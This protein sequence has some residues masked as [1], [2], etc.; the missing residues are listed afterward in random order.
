DLRVFG[1][2][3]LLTTSTVLAFGL[4]PAL[5]ATGS[6]VPTSLAT[7]VV[8]S[9]GSRGWLSRGL[10]VGQ[11]LLCTVSLIVAGVFLRTVQNLRG[12]DA[13]YVEQQLLVADVQLPGGSDELRWA[14]LDQLH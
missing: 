7:R 4:L 5:R 12:Q 9:D 2:T 8:T 14:L 13:G 1:F 11:V 3:L 10:T 6:L